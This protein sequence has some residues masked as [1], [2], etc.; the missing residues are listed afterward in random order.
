MSIFTY[1]GRDKNGKSCS[2]WTEADT[3]K[4][5]RAALAEQ[6]V[7]T[8]SLTEVSSVTR[9]TGLKTRSTLYNELGVLLA[10]GF[11]IEQATS[12]LIG[13]TSDPSLASFLPVLRE[14]I[15]NG[16]TLSGAIAQTLADIP[17]FEKSALET[18]ENSGIQG[19]MLITLSKFLDAE[20]A[21]KEKITS[22]LTYPLAVLVLA[23]GLLSLMVYVILPKASE[24]FMQFGDSLPA[25]SKALV[26][27]APK[28]MTAVF[29]AIAILTAAVL[30]IRK[31]AKN[32]LSTA[33][34]LEK[35]LFKVPFIK[36]LL[37]QLWAMRFSG[38]MS[39]L[40]KAGV[41]PQSAIEV[42][43]A[44][45][46]S[47]WTDLLA[48]EAATKVKNGESLSKAVGGI[49]PISHHLTE[50]VRIG[51]TSGNLRD[52]LEQASARYRQSYETTLAKLLGLLEPALIVTVG[53][54]VLII[55]LAVL[56]PMLELARSVTG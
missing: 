46:G 31:K 20:S 16:A 50:W 23:I 29:V 2:G 19:P 17:A 32:N 38:T 40:M 44:A 30:Q 10:S 35:F 42:S 5:A 25:A 49:T 4:S 3:P 28:I 21:T 48:K 53:I 13:E 56:R 12:L 8:T 7:L 37:P 15:R 34:R 45:T 9:K 27:W 39:L 47:S 51:E 24:M 11:N 41:T 1:K 36:E 26:L 43:G 54:V 6:G 33:V 22:A 55:A 52:M 14:A 18:A